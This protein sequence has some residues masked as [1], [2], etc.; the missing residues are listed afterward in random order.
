MT[1]EE[2]IEELNSL[3]RLGPLT[4]LS[5]QTL[6]AIKEATIAYEEQESI[7]DKIRADIKSLPR[8]GSNSNRY[9]TV[10]VDVYEVLKIIDKYK[11]ESEES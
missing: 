4:G 9:L 7:L 8:Y 2:N 5:P 10:Y 1:K 3:L 6:E 11:T